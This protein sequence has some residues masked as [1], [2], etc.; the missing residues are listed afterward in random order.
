MCEAVWFNCEMPEWFPFAGPDMRVACCAP[1]SDE[2]PLVPFI[3]WSR[4]SFAPRRGKP[5]SL[6]LSRCT[7]CHLW[8]LTRPQCFNISLSISSANSV[9]PVPLSLCWYS[10]WIYQGW[11][12]TNACEGVGGGGE[13]DGKGLAKVGCGNGR[14]LLFKRNRS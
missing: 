4:S 9:S 7:S 6:C 8:L 10:M 2:L 13:G 14:G 1:G 12:C 11:I 5:P 3:S